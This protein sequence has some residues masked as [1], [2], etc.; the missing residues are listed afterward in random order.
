MKQ[1]PRAVTTLGGY[2][3]TL[4]SDTGFKATVEKPCRAKRLSRSG[5]RY[6]DEDG[7]EAWGKIMQLLEQAEAEAQQEVQQLEEVSDERMANASEVWVQMSKMG[8]D[9]FRFRCRIVCG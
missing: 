8:R 9:R 7:K 4:R 6:K 5:E 3:Q 1:A 2:H